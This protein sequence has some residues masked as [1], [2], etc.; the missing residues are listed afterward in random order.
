MAEYSPK[1]AAELRRRRRERG[2]SLADLSVRVHY[3]KGYLSKIE[4]LV[5]PAGPDLARLCDAAL[6]ADGELSKLVPERGIEQ[7]DPIGAAPEIDDEEVLIMTLTPQ[8][9]VQFL[10]ISRRRLL[11]LGGGAVAG[12][13]LTGAASGGHA[14]RG[15]QRLDPALA[16]HFEGL[17]A[18]SR[19][20]GQ[21]FR[22]RSVLPVVESQTRMLAAYIPDA[23]GSQQQELVK[24]HGRTAE[25]AGWMAQEAGDVGAARQWIRQA[26]TAAKDA[27]D[28][29]LLAYAYVREA[30]LALY[31]G[32]GERTVALARQARYGAVSARVRGLAAEREAQGHALAGRYDDYRRALEEASALLAAERDKPRTATTLGSTTVPDSGRLVAGWS[33]Y[34]LRR[35]DEAAALLDE[36]TARIS[37]TGRRAAARFGARRALAHAA[38]GRPHRAAEITAGFLDA[39]EAVDSATIRTDLRR[40]VAV[41]TP[42][43][44]TA[45]V[46]AIYPRLLTLAR[47]G[48]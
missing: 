12:G 15:R 2:W 30:E 11:T 8:G 32:E 41:L 33:L 37:P 5:K 1:F 45:P 35:Y 36:E 48:T 6:A 21:S 22:P 4:N 38:A 47:T 24:L 40:L 23:S 42:N 29:D 3:S 26:V 28:A 19:R 20:L 25:F 13:A 43:R 16:G 46:Q 10:P 31:E 14:L 7:V 27:D 34:D 44:H 18:D 17:L 9:T 39:A